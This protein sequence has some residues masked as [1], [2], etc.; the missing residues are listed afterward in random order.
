MRM[1]QFDF[2]SIENC[3][4]HAQTLHLLLHIFPT[5]KNFSKQDPTK[6]LPFENSNVHLY[7]ALSI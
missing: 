3:D 5:T 1:L 7:T 6:C 4:G 2:P